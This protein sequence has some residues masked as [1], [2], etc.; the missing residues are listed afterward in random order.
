MAL[1]TVLLRKLKIRSSLRFRFVASFVLFALVITA[2]YAILVYTLERTMANELCKKRIASEIRIFAKLYEMDPST[3]LPADED[4]IAYLGTKQMPERIK[5]I[6][7]GHTDGIHVVDSEEVGLKREGR[8]KLDR[9]RRKRSPHP[10]LFGVHTLGDGQKIFVF[11]DLKYWHQKKGELLQ[12]TLWSYGIAFLL[13]I[14]LG[15]LS[16]RQVIR[17]LRRLMRVVE[18]TDPDEIHTGFSRDF[19]KDEFGAL[20]TALDNAFQRVRKFV[21]RE[22]QF[23]RDA[24]HELRTPVTVIKGAIELLKM[25]PVEDRETQ[26]KLIK[27]IERSS[28]DMETTIESLLWLARENGSSTA[29]QPARLIELVESAIEQNQHLLAGKPVRISLSLEASPIISAPAG[30]P[31]IA[32]SNLIRNAC[33]FTTEGEIIITLQEDRIIVSDSGIGIPEEKLDEIT[34]PEISGA[35]SSG[36]GFGLDIVSRLCSRFNWQLK[37]TSKSGEGTMVELI[38]Y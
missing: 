2:V 27:R 26:D 20:A 7:E 21:K 31:A 33:Q 9:H 24:S 1:G 17:P 12:H 6:V 37:I 36:F 11:I 16:A 32:V 13:A 14:I 19:K 18:K 8:S 29:T 34:K 4:I 28:R 30:I 15:T 10:P 23:T 25:T 35:D 3:P 38:F 22:H 5:R